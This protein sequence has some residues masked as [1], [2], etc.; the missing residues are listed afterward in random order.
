MLF[1]RG[2][3]HPG[4]AGGPPSSLITV[5]EVFLCLSNS[6]GYGQNDTMVFLVLFGLGVI[7]GT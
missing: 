3:L 5:L 1:L 6:S 7:M 4:G 2:E